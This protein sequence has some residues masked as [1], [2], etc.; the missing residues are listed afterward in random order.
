[1]DALTQDLAVDAEPS[2]IDFMG[3]V[4]NAVYL[5]WVQNVVIAHWQRIAGPEAVAA[6]VWVAL[7]HEI[8]YRRPA[9]LNDRLVVTAV[10]EQVRRESA[11]YETTVRRGGDVLARV[12]SRWCCLDARTLRPTR[13]GGDIVK[14]F[15]MPSGTLPQEVDRS[16]RRGT[17]LQNSGSCSQGDRPEETIPF[18]ADAGETKPL[19]PEVPSKHPRPAA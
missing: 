4:N 8:V 18:A 1:M 15:L 14:R 7:R 2:D 17:V 13:L 11:F 6:H 9:F 19:V 12:K 10:L 16:V 5:K 3:H